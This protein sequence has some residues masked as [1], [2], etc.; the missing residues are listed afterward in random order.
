MCRS[1]IRIARN[2]VFWVGR[3]APL[4]DRCAYL[5][6]LRLLDSFISG[7]ASL[8]AGPVQA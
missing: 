3:P 4:E 6:A 5:R 7:A 2:S 1:I 8:A